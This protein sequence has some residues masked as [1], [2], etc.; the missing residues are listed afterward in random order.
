MAETGEF[1][2]QIDDA[3][4]EPLPMARLADVLR[5]LAAI[6][7]ERGAVRSARACGAPPVN[8]ATRLRK[9]RRIVGG[10]ARATARPFAARRNNA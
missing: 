6:F 5:D 2:F 8:S 7:G 10:I 3:A 4:A 9:R 1:R